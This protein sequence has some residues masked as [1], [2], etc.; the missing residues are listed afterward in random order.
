[1]IN[2]LL[3]DL[4]KKD[5]ISSINKFM[6]NEKIIQRKYKLYTKTPKNL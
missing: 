6:I 5:I 2:T 1:M 3:M 4:L